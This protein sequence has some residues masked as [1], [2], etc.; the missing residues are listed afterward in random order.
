M[1]SNVVGAGHGSHWKSK[2]IYDMSLPQPDIPSMKAILVFATTAALLSQT[3]ADPVAAYDATRI[4]ER[5]F[6]QSPNSTPVNSLDGCE[7]VSSTGQGYYYYEIRFSAKRQYVVKGGDSKMSWEDA[8][9]S[10]N[11]K[12]AKYFRQ[13]DYNCWRKAAPYHEVCIN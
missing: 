13:N 4:G 9:A 5:Y 7:I 2:V 8:P 3:V 1:L 12:P 10:L 6:K 11:G